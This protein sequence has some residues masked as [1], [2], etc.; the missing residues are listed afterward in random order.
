MVSIDDIKEFLNLQSPDCDVFLTK[1]RDQSI[2]KINN[3]CR[4]Q[5]NFGSCYDYISGNYEQTF[6]LLNYP[7]D[8]IVHI[9]YRKESTGYDYDVVA[10]P[11]SDLILINRIGKI[12]LKGTTAL[13]VGDTNIEIKYYAGYSDDAETAYCQVPQDLKHA[14]LLMTVDSFLKS[15]K[16]I[17]NQKG[18]RFGMEHFI[19][20]VSDSINSSRVDLKYKQDDYL[21]ILKRY[22]ATRI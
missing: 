13:P 1:M 2:A 20:T 9:K 12:I 7:V 19:H 10:S 6:L 3:Y 4:R 8:S 5:L 21:Q 14:C 18:S 15:Y 16:D 11:I 17:D 22:C